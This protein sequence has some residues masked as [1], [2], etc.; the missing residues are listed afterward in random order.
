EVPRA[1]VAS[2]DDEDTAVVTVETPPATTTA[3]GEILVGVV[4]EL[5]A[6]AVEHGDADPR[7]TVDPGAHGETDDWRFVVA[8][9]GPGIPDHEVEVFRR[10]EETPLQHGRGLGLWLVRWGV[11]R[12]GGSVQFDTSDGTTVTVTLPESLFERDAT[13]ERSVDAERPTADGG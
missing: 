10:V 2:A 1:T 11:D 4:R 3:N 5:V 9:D 12:L 6:N 8:D 7:V 13:T